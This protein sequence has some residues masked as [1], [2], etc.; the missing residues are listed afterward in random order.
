MPFQPAFSSV[1]A[2]IIIEELLPYKQYVPSLTINAANKCR[3]QQQN[4]RNKLLQ[5]Q[6]GGEEGQLVI[7]RPGHVIH[8]NN[9][10]EYYAAMNAAENSDKLIV[11]DC[12]APWC[13]PCQQIAPIFERNVI[14]I[15]LNV[16][17]VPASIKTELSIW[18]LPTFIFYKDGKK[19]GSFMG[20]NERLLLRG[21]ENNGQVS[22]CS[23]LCNIQ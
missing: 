21:L 4:S 1:H 12:F 20:A 9:G 18:V 16:D 17:N 6:G 19:V 5:T 8:V 7:I 3:K 23:S 10:D 22:I 2:V 11:I 14:F 13:P 15:K